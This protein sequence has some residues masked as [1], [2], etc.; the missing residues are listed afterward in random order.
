AHLVHSHF[1]TVEIHHFIAVIRLVLKSHVVLK[2]RATAAHYRDAQRRRYR[3]LHAHDFLHLAA[4]NWSK[5]DHDFFS[6]HRGALRGKFL[7]TAILTESK[8]E[9]TLQVALRKRLCTRISHPETLC[10]Q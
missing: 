4:G 2:T 3:G 8:S 1:Q 7:Q 10:I 9:C 5:T 6:L